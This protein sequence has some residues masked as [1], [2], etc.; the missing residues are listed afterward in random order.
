MRN[1]HPVCSKTKLVSSY[2]IGITVIILLFPFSGL[3]LFGTV[4]VAAGS[5]SSSHVGGQELGEQPPQQT[6]EA[7]GGSNSI[8]GGANNISTTASGIVGTENNTLLYENPEYGIQ[9]R[10]PQ[11]WIYLEMD[12]AFPLEFQVVFMSP[13]EA[14]KAG[15]TQETGVTSDT[16]S[17]VSVMIAQLPFGNVDVQLLGDIITSGLAS[18][19]SEIISNNTDVTLSGMPAFEVVVS[20]PEDN[21]RQLQ[22]WTIHGGK[23]Y[24]VGYVSH[25]SRFE[26][27][28]P[29]AQD[30][31]RSFIIA[32]ETNTATQIDNSNVNNTVAPDPSTI[33]TTTQSMNLEAA[34]QQYLAVWNQTEFQVAFNTYIEPGSATGYGIFEEL[35]NNDDIFRP[36][37]TIQLYAEPVGFGQQQILDENGNTVYHMNLTANILISD[38]NGNELAN[39][40]DAPLIDII[41][42]RQNTEMQLILTVTQ[43]DPFPVGDYIITYIVYDRVKGESFQID[44]RITIAA[45]DDVTSG[46]TDDTIAGQE[47]QHQQ[48]QNVEWLQYENATY[49][50]RMLYPSNWIQEDGTT[51][52][53]DRFIFVSNF[54]TPEQEV[55]SYAYVAI[56]IDNMPQ[57]MSLGGYLNDTINSYMQ[58]PTFENFQVLSSSTE[59]FTLAGMPAYILEA[60]YRDPEFGP[61]HMLEVGTILDNTVY[62]VQYIADTPI[63]QTHFSLAERMIESFDI[64]Q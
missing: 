23:G 9:I 54:V 43:D 52:E 19:G 41:S 14:F 39:I 46:V 13:T 20:Q 45:E 37:E 24:G 64:M 40:E 36:G 42:H 56:S 35:D 60:S 53:D 7:R 62:Y 22:V 11:D 4:N 57:S 47:Q 63:Y 18:D 49:G 30:M 21:T 8:T 6:P 28:L 2:G 55:G 59:Q 17:G 44:K 48:E 10:Y 15:R 58:D 1:I 51:A 34:R 16:P 31:I 27:S 26:Q 12:T 32:D 29:I 61:Q 3:S 33:S 50:V 5:L 25:E 38:T